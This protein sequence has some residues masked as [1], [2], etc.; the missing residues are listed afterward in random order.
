M[1]RTFLLIAVALIAALALG[2]LA[3]CGGQ[4]PAPQA[5]APQ[6]PAGEEAAP[7]TEVAASPLS[8]PALWEFYTDW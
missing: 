2:A 1:K 4:A 5:D 3:G 6:V 7:G 8:G